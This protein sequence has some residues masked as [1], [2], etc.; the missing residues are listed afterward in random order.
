M[1][2][3]ITSNAKA[4]ASHLTD[5]IRQI[6]DSLGGQTRMT[7]DEYRETLTYPPPRELPTYQR[8][9][10]MLAGLK[11]G[12]VSIT[13]AQFG[14]W[15]GVYRVMKPR[16]AQ[17][18]VVEGRQARAHLGRWWTLQSKLREYLGRAQ[19]EGRIARVVVGILRNVF[20]AGAGGT[21]RS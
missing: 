11:S 18:V 16:Y 21:G 8:T 3:S 1:R 6:G 4:V 9:Y 13:R 10:E 2:V 20:G 5:G 14:K 15:T 7:M 19:P 17:W 12:D